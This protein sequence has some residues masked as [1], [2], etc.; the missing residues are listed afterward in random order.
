[1]HYPPHIPEE[2]RFAVGHE[3]FGLVPGLMM[4]ATIWLREHNR[5]CHIMKQEHPDWDD[6]R[7]FQTTR[8]ILIGESLEII[9]NLPDL[10]NL[11]R[12][13][14]F[15][16]FFVPR[17]DPSKSWC[18][19]RT[20]FNTWVVTTSSSSLTRSFSSMSASSTRTALIWIQHSVSLAPTDAWHISDPGPGLR[21]PPVL[22]LTTLFWPNTASTTWWIPSPN[23]RLEGWVS[24]I[25]KSFSE[26]PHVVPKGFLS[27]VEVFCKTPHKMKVI[28]VQCCFRP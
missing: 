8:L 24:R 23:R 9:R 12:N 10:H 26:K 20:M 11:W 7:I 19:S 16:A 1:M 6:E 3:A 2:Q 18:G 4:Y 28:G 17:W 21:L 22:C 15:P 25:D 27:S 13:S 14:I 5:V